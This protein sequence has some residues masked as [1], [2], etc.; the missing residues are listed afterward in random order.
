MPDDKEKLSRENAKLIG[1]TI[2]ITTFVLLGAAYFLDHY[3]K[4]NIFSSFLKTDNAPKHFVH[5]EMISTSG[6]VSYTFDLKLGFLKGR[7]AKKCEKLIPRIK[8]DILMLD[9]GKDIEERNMAVVK[10]K[11]SSAVCKHCPEAEGNIMFDKF[12]HQ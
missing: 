6:E 10:E 4:S 11:I 2:V 8:N 7:A 5:V 9:L 1:L 3:L 12:W